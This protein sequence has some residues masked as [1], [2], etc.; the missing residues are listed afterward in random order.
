MHFVN[1]WSGIGFVVHAPGTNQKSPLLRNS[2]TKSMSGDAAVP[3]KEAGRSGILAI[4]SL[5]LGHGWLILARPW[6][7]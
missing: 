5:R 6:S 1:P 4:V 3:E 2:P 7:L